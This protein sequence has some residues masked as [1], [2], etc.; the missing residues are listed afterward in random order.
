[1]AISVLVIGEDGET[2]FATRLIRA[3]PPGSDVSFSSSRSTSKGTFDL[4]I[5]DATV[6]ED[7]VETINILRKQHPH[8]I[9]LGVSLS[10][11]WGRIRNAFRAGVSD[12]VSK[13]ME[14]PELRKLISELLRLEQ[15]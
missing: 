9:F 8:A 6:V 10:L 14:E 12:Y 15:T 3:L 7:F 11:T 4:I 1:M 2:T 5:V 13:S